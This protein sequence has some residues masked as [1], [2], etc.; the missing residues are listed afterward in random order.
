M[1]TVGDIM[2]RALVWL[3][4]EA[5]VKEAARK[6]VDENEGCILVLGADRRLLGILSEGDFLGQRDGLPWSSRVAASVFGQYI[7]LVGL[8]QAYD[9]AAE[10]P[11]REVMTRDVATVS[12]QTPL[13][14]LASVMLARGVKHVPVVNG[15]TVVGVASR[16]DLLK[17]MVGNRAVK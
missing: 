13:E 7:D 12:I 5:T 2:S 9:S 4:P 10:R 11:V 8:Q 15:A 3:P 1:Q 17:V 16:H 14:D 6:M